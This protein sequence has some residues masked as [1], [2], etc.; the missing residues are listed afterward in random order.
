[1]L[2][3]R[4]SSVSRNISSLSEQIRSAGS[5]YPKMIKQL[6]V[7]ETKLQSTE[8]D[9]E[10]LELRYKNSQI[11]KTEYAKLFEEYQ[12]KIEDAEV[13]IDGVLLR[14]RE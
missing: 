14:L 1:M 6:E 9:L 12:S 11:S 10:R 2:D 3:G 4:M 8:K 7:A 5:K 13:T